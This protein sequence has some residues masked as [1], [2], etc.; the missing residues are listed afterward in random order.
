LSL[1]HFEEVFIYTKQ[2]GKGPDDIVFSVLIQFQNL[3]AYLYTKINGHNVPYSNPFFVM[4]IFLCVYNLFLFYVLVWF[5]I[6]LFENENLPEK[7]QQQ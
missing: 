7:K 4:V 6:Y 3:K 2:Q 1:D 5:E